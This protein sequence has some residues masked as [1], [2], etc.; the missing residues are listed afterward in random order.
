MVD[1]VPYNSDPSNNSP[2][3]ASGSNFPCKTTG[4][5]SV[6]EE[7]HMLKGESQSM[8]FH[9][10]TTH[11]GGSCQISITSD[12]SPSKDTTRS[13]IMSIEGGCMD[14]TVS[15]FNIGSSSTMV[16][17]FSPNFTIPDSFKAGQ[18]TIAWTWFNRI[19]NREMYMNCTPITITENNSSSKGSGS[20]EIEE[21]SPSLPFSLPT[22]TAA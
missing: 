22:S 4:D 2:L 7:N 5:Y 16:T 6:I 10:G 18:Y 19:G 17:H 8:I 20:A 12:R 1:P 3:D 14:E 21:T 11:G 13:V 15:D 9:G